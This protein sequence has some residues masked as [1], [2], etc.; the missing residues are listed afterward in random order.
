MSDSSNENASSTRF[1]SADELLAEIEN[2]ETDHARR[3]ALWRGRALHENAWKESPRLHQALARRFLDEGAHRIALEIVTAARRRWEDDLLLRQLMGLSLAG[4]GATRGANELLQQTWDDLQRREQVDPYLLEET[5]GTL[6]RT[7]KDL[8]LRETEQ[9][10]RRQLLEQSCRLYE[11]A[12]VETGRYWTGINCATL[13]TLL[14]DFRTASDVV[15]KVHRQCLDVL[16]TSAGDNADRY[17]VL[18]TLGEAEVVREKF[19]EARRWYRRAAQSAAGRV[20]HLASTRRQAR[21]LMKHFNRPADELDEWLPMPKVAV[22]AGHMIDQPGR[23]R[24]RFPQRR[25]DAVKSAIRSWLK[26]NN[27]AIGFSSLA[28]GSDILFQEALQQL[29]G[30]SHVVLPYRETEF[31][32]DSVAITRNPEK[33]VKRFHTALEASTQV[34]YASGERIQAGAVSYEYANLML[35]GLAQRKAQELET[36]LLGLAVWNGQPGDGPGGTASVVERWA[37]QQ[38]PIDR[39]DPIGRGKGRLTARRFRRKARRQGTSQADPTD[40][41][42]HT[43]TDRGTQVRAMLFGDVVNF[44]NLTESEVPRFVKRFMGAVA[45]VIGRHRDAVLLRNT[46]GDALYLVFRD[47]DSAGRC[48]LDMQ[49]TVADTS[50]TDVGLPESLRLRIALHAGPLYRCRN[51]VTRRINY[52]GTHVS[53]AARLEPKTPAGEVYA[54][55]AFAALA[56]VDGVTDWTCEYVRQLE[57]AKHYGT[58][59]TYVVRRNA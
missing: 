19:T 29:G 36:A 2:P 13:A 47:V 45:R 52:T 28:C 5:L 15:Q 50:W 32:Q 54:S 57:W 1:P 20:G 4:S 3:L 10:A 38:L 53:R 40:H 11:I 18:A 37:E 35:T 56:A 27:V 9:A 16:Q 59:P 22:F 7:Y 31:L 8:A 43:T 12:Y 58:F 25:A 17:W 51:P 23:P 48:A 24:E 55:E 6:A 49:E 26:Q 41:R 34:I 46:W 44:R 39:I 21:L 30:Q 42:S 33:W 14:G